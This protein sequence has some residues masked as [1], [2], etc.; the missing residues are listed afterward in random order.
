MDKENKYNIETVI[1][2]YNKK[3]KEFEMFLDSIFRDYIN[4]EKILPAELYTDFNNTK[5]KKISA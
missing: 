5:I 2:E 1:F 3:D 4:N